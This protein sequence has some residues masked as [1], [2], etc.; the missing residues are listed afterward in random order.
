MNPLTLAMRL[1]RRDVRDRSLVILVAALMT[2]VAAVTAIGLLI[3]RTGQVVER[4]A[5]ALRGADLTVEN[6]HPM[7]DDWDGQT[8]AYDIQ[9]NN[10]ITLHTMIFHKANNQLITLKTINNTYP[11][12]GV[13]S[14]ADRCHSPL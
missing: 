12:R 11:L 1:L 8:A 14:V 2:A 3:D 7:P 4:Q 6:T 13:L 5:G 9:T 10:T